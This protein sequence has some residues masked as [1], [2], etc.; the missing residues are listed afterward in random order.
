MLNMMTGMGEI[1]RN[2]KFSMNQLEEG[3]KSLQLSKSMQD[4][5]KSINDAQIQMVKL[6]EIH[7]RLGRTAGKGLDKLGIDATN[8]IRQRQVE[9]TSIFTNLQQIASNGGVHPITGLTTSQYMGSAEVQIALISA[10]REEADVRK[11]VEEV[12][13]QE[14]QAEKQ[15]GVAKQ[16]SIGITEKLS[17]E[18]TDFLKPYSKPRTAH[19]DNRKF[20]LT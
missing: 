4:F 16:Q 19:T 12:I 20:C 5:A 10:K 17:Q 8:A 15:N 3:N 9:M 18:E 6:E 14:E 13:K 11:R 1:I 2:V 7:D